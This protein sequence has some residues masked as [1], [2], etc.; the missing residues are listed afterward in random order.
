M[1]SLS[2]MFKEIEEQ[3]TNFIKI[4]EQKYEKEIDQFYEEYNLI[5][6]KLRENLMVIID[7]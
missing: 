5:N 3:L 1:T 2:T 6:D 4:E 7:G